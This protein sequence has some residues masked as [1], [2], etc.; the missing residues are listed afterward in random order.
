P[1][2]RAAARQAPAPAAPVLTLAE[3]ERL[4]VERNLAV[5]AAR[6]GVDAQRAQRLVAGSRPPATGT[7]ATNFGQFYETGTASP[8]FLSPGNNV[9]LGISVVV[10][11]GGK[12]SLRVRTADEQISAAEAQVLDALRTQVFAVR[13]AFY[14][15]LLARANLEVAQANIASINRTEALLRR[16]A[17]LGQIPEG[18]VIRFQASR[19]PFEAE[20]AAGRQALAA[21]IADLTALVAGDA[22]TAS[23]AAA[24][25]PRGRFE[26]TRP[27]GLTRAELADAV[28]RRADVVA[29][30]R[31]SAAAAA[32][33]ALAEAG[34]SRDVTVELN[35][36]RGVVD[37]TL[38]NGDN[39]RARQNVASLSLSIPLFTTRIVEGNIGVAAA[40]QRQA[41][42]QA[43]AALAQ[44]RA[45]FATAWSAY[46][47]AQRLLAVYDGGALR[48]A[49]E[50]YAIAE[51]AYLAGGRSLLDVLDA[52][53]TLN[54]T[55]T[56]AN[57]ARRAYSV[58]LAD[59]ERSSGT[60]GIL[61]AR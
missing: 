53:R 39:Q 60:S 9:T 24:Y 1:R 10:E 40:Q 54:A 2:E 3:A 20:V 36:G 56:A 31:S 11:R 19:P 7:F 45:D 32:N 59:L 4:V 57:E 49:E 17:E 38:P 23:G 28:T 22:V 13:Q 48:R 33:R 6:F 42:A 41:E 47:Q 16:Q 58:A 61:T 55:R 12:R 29:A 34:R 8:Q 21:R 35:A 15:A 52:L 27:L 26:P 25:E 18:D 37:R 46:E 14:G 43:A 5:V 44:A 30:E 51:R 50:A